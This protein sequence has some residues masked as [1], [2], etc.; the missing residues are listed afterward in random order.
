ML[1]LITHPFALSFR[2]YAC[3]LQLVMKLNAIQEEGHRP[4]RRNLLVA[5]HSRLG[6]VVGIVAHHIRLGCHRGVHHRTNTMLAY[7]L[8]RGC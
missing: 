5:L 2:R 7:S 3:M 1:D 8:R 4:V 6:E